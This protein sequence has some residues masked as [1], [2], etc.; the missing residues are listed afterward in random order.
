MLEEKAGLILNVNVVK[1]IFQRKL[2]DIGITYKFKVHEAIWL[3]SIVE[4]LISEIIELAGNYVKDKKRVR[5]DE[6]AIVSTI[7]MDKELFKLF[8]VDKIK[9][10]CSN[11]GL[12]LRLW[13]ERIM[14]QVHPECQMKL[15]TTNYIDTLIETYIKSFINAFPK[16]QQN[17]EDIDIAQI[18]GKT[19]QGKLSE[20][21]VINCQK[22]VNKY[23]TK[24]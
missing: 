16:D 4:Y 20:F 5:I 7:K 19:L 12:G 2:A 6:D 10:D 24:I 21:G 23:E 18:I 15:G 22:A 14:K 8:N 1:K 11:Y 17:P 3:A 13:I 9:Y